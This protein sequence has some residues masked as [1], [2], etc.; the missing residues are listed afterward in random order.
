MYG[1]YKLRK[2][3]KRFASDTEK[4]DFLVQK[5]VRVAINRTMPIVIYHCLSG[6]I[7]IWLISFFGSTSSISQLG[8]LG[9][10]SMVFGLF[11]ALFSTLVVP[12]FSR[13]KANKSVLLRTFLLIQGGTATISVTVIFFLWL[14]SDQLL[15]VLGQGYYGL[16]YE[17]LLLGISSGI[18]LMAGRVLLVNSIH[19]RQQRYKGPAFLGWICCKL[20]SS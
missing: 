14:F 8:A 17:L 20:S 13:L 12:R 4:P 2:I 10:I 7:S 1:N 16:S 15:W 9:R 11:A 3:S 18:I 19:N 6:Q 5:K